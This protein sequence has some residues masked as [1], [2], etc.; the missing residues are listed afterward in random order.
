ML[1][2]C[3]IDDTRY[4][5]MQVILPTA[6]F[7]TNIINITGGSMNKYYKYI[8]HNIEAVD[9]YINSDHFED[10]QVSSN[11]CSVDYNQTYQP[12]EMEVNA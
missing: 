1:W 10:C 3:G 12:K 7:N 5:L 9:S 6:S 11:T 2:G 4:L 8:P